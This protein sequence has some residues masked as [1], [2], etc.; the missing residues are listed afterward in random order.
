MPT[1]VSRNLAPFSVL[2]NLTLSMLTLL[3]LTG[4][5]YAQAGTD[6]MLKEKDEAD[7][8]AAE[9]YYNRAETDQKYQE[10]LRNQQAPAAASNDPWGTVRPATSPAKPAAKPAVKTATGASKSATGSAKPAIGAA[11]P[12]TGTTPKGQ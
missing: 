1:L 6:Q 3:A 12:G 8:K 4:A 9:E 11:A 5:A 7:R 10:T 2:R